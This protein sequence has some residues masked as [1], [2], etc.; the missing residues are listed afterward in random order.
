VVTVLT[1]LLSLS[2]V[3]SPATAN[4]RYAAIV[5]EANSGD[6]LFS[7]NAESHRFP[8]SLT[9]MM[10]LYMTFEALEQGKLKK[11]QKLKVSKRAAGQA[12]SKLWLKAGDTITVDDAI[13][14]MV[15]RSANDV[16][17][18]LA[19]AISKTEYQ[20]ALDMSKKAR[21][22]GMRKTRFQNASGLPHRR[23]KSTAHDMAILGQQIRQDFPQYFPY[24]SVKRFVYNGKTY[25]SHNNLLKGYKG[26]D[27]IKTG[28]TSASGFNLVTSI[29]RDGVRLIGVV[30][31][32]RT[33]KSRDAHMKYIL[34]KTFKRVKNNPSLLPQLA[35]VPKPRLKPGQELP[36]QLA[37]ITPRNKPKLVVSR[38]DTGGLPIIAF[39]Y[40]TPVAPEQVFI[41][42]GDAGPGVI[43]PLWGVQIGAYSDAE[44]AR[45]HLGLARNIVPD[46]LTP[47]RTAIFPLETEKGTMYRAR[48]GPL[49][50]TQA[51]SVCNTLKSKGQDCFAL[52]GTGWPH[53]Q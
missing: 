28:Y 41:E 43:E 6:V 24:F 5:I 25:T 35:K 16:A 46:V 4:S 49:S 10:T 48:F 50:P 8:A 23:Q 9:K 39:G 37:S 38:K 22:L 2:F 44:H 52:Q 36:T 15:T 53:S 21:Q 1:F 3:S 27:G 13:K 29:E 18:V 12:P 7:R 32:G 42:Q 14:A 31:G 47:S 51:K 40:E 17:T 26:T 30:L 19:E 20:F 34:D 45:E 11:D 33:A